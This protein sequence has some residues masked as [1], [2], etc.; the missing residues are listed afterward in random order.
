VPSLG[1]DPEAGVFGRMQ[2]LN[3]SLAGRTM[4]RD[5]VQHFQQRGV[6][7]YYAL[8]WFLSQAEHV[9]HNRAVHQRFME[10]V[11]TH[12]PVLPD[13]TFGLLTELS[14]F[15]CDELHL[16]PAGAKL[17]AR[18]ILRSLAEVGLEWGASRHSL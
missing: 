3:L 10:E 13:D 6:A 1:G 8:L 15:F 14:L 9:E 2:P 18:A 7:V 12:L 11:R 4:L 17:R 5:V 16:S